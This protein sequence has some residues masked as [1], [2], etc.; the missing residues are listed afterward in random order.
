MSGST[1]ES[2]G[3]RTN[4]QVL[5]QLKNQ[6]AVIV[7]FCDL[8][9]ADAPE[10][11]RRTADLMEVHKAARQAM[12]MMPEVAQRLRTTTEDNE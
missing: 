4:A 6:L 11:D 1:D 9:M 10:G 8:L 7:G 5:H 2:I 3:K 12:A